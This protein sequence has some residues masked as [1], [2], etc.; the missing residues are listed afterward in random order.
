ML[1]AAP[2]TA[3]AAGPGRQRL[4]L[5]LQAPCACSTSASAPP[6]PTTPPCS[7]L[8][9][10]HAKRPGEGASLARPRPGSG[11][12]SHATI[13]GYRLVGTGRPPLCAASYGR[14]VK[15][16]CY[17]RQFQ[18]F[19]M[20]QRYVASFSYRCCKSRSRCC[21]CCN[22]C[23]RMLQAPILNVSSY[24]FTHMMQVFYMDVAYVYNSFKCFLGIFA[25]VSDACFICFQSLIVIVA[26]G[27]FKTS[28][29][30]LSGR[31]SAV[32][33]RCQTRERGGSPHWHGQAL[34]AC[35][36]A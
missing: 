17:K 20:F 21:T 19:Q 28:V 4:A 8:R 2:P 6:S 15:N 1:S 36:P 13:L 11:A 23:T 16:A 12:T 35:G 9:R 10:A 5:R 7:V 26:L 25:S 32:S 33:P 34:R 3:A 14:R 29:L 24:V 18:V 27:C 31:F 22:G 30:H